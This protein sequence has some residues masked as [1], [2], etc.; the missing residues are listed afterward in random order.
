MNE[1]CK[2]HLEPYNLKT[3]KRPTFSF[4]EIWLRMQQPVLQQQKKQKQKQKPIVYW[5]VNCVEYKF[6]EYHTPFLSKRSLNLIQSGCLQYP[7][8]VLFWFYK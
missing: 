3:I 4:L 2:P 1:C 5:S 7:V 8:S 6:N